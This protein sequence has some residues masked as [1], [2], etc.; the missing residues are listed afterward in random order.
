M[1][2][3]MKVCERASAHRIPLITLV[4]GLSARRVLG[5]EVLLKWPNDVVSSAGDKVAGLLAERTDGLVVVG[6]GVNL[7]WP[8][9]PD[10]MGALYRDDPGPEAAPA[11]AVAWA[12]DLFAEL[13]AGPEG[14]LPAEYEQVSTTIGATQEVPRSRWTP[15]DT[16]SRFGISR[17]APASGF[18]R[19]GI[20]PA[21]DGATSSYPPVN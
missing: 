20:P 8:D 16:S 19:H 2:V 14:F 15:K 1:T 5:D 13:A 4:A 10:G 18:G 7:Y 21:R 11:I 6:L 3:T 12:E 17:M 9:A